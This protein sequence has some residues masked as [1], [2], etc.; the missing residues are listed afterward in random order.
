MIR[1]TKH[2]LTNSNFHKKELY[3]SFLQE[4][5]MFSSQLLDY[6]WSTKIYYKDKFFNISSDHLDIPPMLSTTKIN[7]PTTLSARARKCAI[8]QVLGIIRA[9]TEKRRKQLY[10]CNKSPSTKLK[11]KLEIPLTK[12][13]ISNLNPEL[14]SICCT[15][16]PT[17]NH[18]TGFMKLFSLGKS[19][20]KIFLPIK[21]HKRNKK[22]SSWDRMNSY[23][24]LDNEVQFRWKKEVK[25]KSVGKILGG[26]QGKH[27][28]LTL[29]DGQITP[30]KD[31]DGHSLDS[32]IASL[33][34]KKKGSQ[35][36][37]KTQSHREN[38]INWSVN[39]LNFNDVKQLNLEEIH[40]MRRGKNVGRIMSHWVYPLIE[41]KVK[42]VCEEQ[43]VL[44]QLQSSSYRSQRCNRCGLVRKGNRKEESYSC[45]CGW[46][47]DS[48][49]NAAMNHEDDLPEIPVS[50]RNL[51]LN[52]KG[53][54]WMPDG[55]YNLNGEVLAVPLDPGMK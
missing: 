19:F 3:L 21:F 13:N 55:C 11:E 26:D 43:G 22:Y 2:S 35:A 31:K 28:V 16:I 36:F 23:L 24:F 41:R 25:K 38:F 54:Y 39:Q 33:A 37:K 15:F 8:T 52:L 6:L 42:S 29:S 10:I 51:K 30:K 49:I 14:N 40:D 27:K 5:R 45:G 53:F 17:E 12:P 4:Y 50:L 18:F 34:R 47:A 9:V 20:G 32:I 1:S 44:V 48:D 46:V 7:I